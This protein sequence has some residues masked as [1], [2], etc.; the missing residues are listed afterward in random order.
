MPESDLERYR[1]LH[2]ALLQ[3]R[4]SWEDGWRDAAD[5]ILPDVARFLATDANDGRR[6]NQKIIDATATQAA[7][8]LMAGMT[9][10]LTSPGRPWFNLTLPDADQA[11]SPEVKH[12]LHTVTADLQAMFHLSNLY[13]ALP[14]GYLDLGMFGTTAAAVLDDPEDG[15]R[16]RPFP[17]GSYVLAVGNRGVV[18]TCIREWRMTVRQIVDEYGEEAVSKRVGDL[19]RRGRTEEWVDVVQ[20]ITPNRDYQPDRLSAKHKRWASC[21]YEKDADK[22]KLRESGFDEFPIL[23]PRWMT[24]GENVY[25][26]GPARQVIGDIKML[27]SEQKVKAQGVE[28]MVNPPLTAPESAR[29]SVVSGHP[30]AISYYDTRDGR[31]LIQ[32]MYNVNLPLDHIRLDIAEAQQ[33]IERAFHADLFLAITRSDRREITAREIEERHEE[34]LLALGPVLERLNDE[35][36]D[37]L[38]DRAFAIRMRQGRIP[39]PPEEIQGMPLRVEYISVLA[40]A[41]KQVGIGAVERYVGFA[42]NAA[43]AEPAV[44]DKVA[45]DEAMSQYGDMLGIDPRIVRSDEEAAQIRQ[46]RAEQQAALQQQQLAQQQAETAKTLSETDTAG[47]N[48]LNQMLRQGAA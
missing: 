13:T 2:G 48:A 11:E 4:R 44:L 12:W 30:G 3:E 29:N 35:L 45:W 10:G 24:I 38:I 15:M 23:A 6:R 33:R 18:D 20:V 5:Y 21:T 19:W 1:K 27:Q 9:S 43:Q 32:P 25:G 40:Q 7:Q 8:V 17:I 37:P 36:L 41:Q 28:K 47:D 39:E 26:I 34:K 42:M 22:R 14:M 46:A 31:P 16:L